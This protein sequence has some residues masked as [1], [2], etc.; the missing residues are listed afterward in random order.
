MFCPHISIIKNAGTVYWLEEY[1][2]PMA[3]LGSRRICVLTY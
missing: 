1:C 3:W 2:F